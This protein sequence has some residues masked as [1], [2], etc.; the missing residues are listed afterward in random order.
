MTMQMI[1]GSIVRLARLQQRVQD[2]YDKPRTFLTPKEKNLFT[3]PVTQR[4]KTGTYRLQL[5]LGMVDHIYFDNK[6]QRTQG[7]SR[8]VIKNWLYNTGN[9]TD[10]N[11]V[12]QEDTTLHDHNRIDD[13]QRRA[14]HAI[15][16]DN[17]VEDKRMQEEE[18]LSGKYNNP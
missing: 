13:T 9:E 3:L 7:T 6:Q 2:Y 15:A 11:D 17:I 1:Y 8:A 12:T 5:W 10:M 4:L 18:R 16:E 14:I